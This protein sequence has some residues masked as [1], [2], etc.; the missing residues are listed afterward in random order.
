MKSEFYTNT[1]KKHLQKL[2]DERD[3]YISN[4]KES[5]GKTKEGYR[6]MADLYDA[7]ISTAENHIAENNG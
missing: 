7:L 3:Y 5:E 2:I 1:S 4:A 6:L